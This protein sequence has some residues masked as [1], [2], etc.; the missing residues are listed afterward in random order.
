MAEMAS[1]LHAVG[2]SGLESSFH[3]WVDPTRFVVPPGCDPGLWNAA[4]SVWLEGPPRFTPVFIHRDYHPGNLIWYRGRI[5]GVVD[6]AHGCAGPAGLDLSTC[7]WNLL[8]HVGVDRAN[9]YVQHYENSTGLATQWFW[10]LDGLLSPD[11]SNWNKPWMVET[12]P[13][14]RLILHRLDQTGE[15]GPAASDLP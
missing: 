11:P 3:S 4:F 15:C 1:R 12:E 9:G 6:W 8:D 2:V 5:S 14:L 13:A 7:W 10:M